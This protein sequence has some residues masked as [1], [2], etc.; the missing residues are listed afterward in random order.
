MLLDATNDSIEPK[1]G[2][3]LDVAKDGFS[4]LP[5]LDIN[6]SH[7]PKIPKKVHYGKNVDQIALA[8]PAIAVPAIVTAIKPATPRWTK[9][10]HLLRL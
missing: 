6:G 2:K 9:A 4:K 7:A 1:T 10:G 5:K 3:S 8:T